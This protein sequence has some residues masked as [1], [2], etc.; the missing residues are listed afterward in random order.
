MTGAVLAIAFCH[1]DPEEALREIDINTLLFFMGLFVLVGGIE[2]A[3]VIEALAK[4]GIELVDG[5]VKTMTFL[6][7]GLS[8]IASAFVDN[9]PFTATMIPL[10]QDMQKL[11]GVE[12]DYLWWSLALGACFGG[13]GTLIGASPNVIIMAEADKAG[14]PV[15]FGKFIKICFPIMSLTLFISGVYLYIRYF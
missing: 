11:M 6:I 1:I 14:Y 8:G 4:Q 2:S 15:S 12:A 9:I 10:I 3:G 13:N 5:D 7:L